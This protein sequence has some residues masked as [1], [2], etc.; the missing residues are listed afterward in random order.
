M[1]EDNGARLEYEQKFG[2]FIRLCADKDAEVVAIHHPEVL[3][4]T[5]GGMVESL[6]RLADAEKVLTIVPRRERG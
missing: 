3:G 4:D 1:T 2:E 5:Y 6:N